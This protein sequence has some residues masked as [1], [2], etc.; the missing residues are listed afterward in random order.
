MVIHHYIKIHPSWSTYFR[1]TGQNM[2]F[3]TF[4]RPVT[5]D[6]DLLGVHLLN[7]KWP[8][9]SNTPTY[10]HS[11]HLVHLTLRYRPK[12]GFQVSYVTFDLWPDLLGEHLLNKKEFTHSNTPPCQNSVQ[13]VHWTSRYRPEHGFQVSYV[14]F[15][16]WPWSLRW[17]PIF[18]K[19]TT[20]ECTSPHQKSFKLVQPFLRSAPDS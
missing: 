2:V 18:K 3:K 20:Y 9:H 13:L 10:Q 7:K 8:T 4:M 11:F 6:L 5:C 15:D 1:N 16:P 12:H 17:K 19:S 14:T